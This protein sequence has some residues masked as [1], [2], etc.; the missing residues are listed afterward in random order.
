MAMIDYKS[1]AGAVIR[2]AIMIG[3]GLWFDNGGFELIVFVLPMII[4]NIVLFIGTVI[5]FEHFFRSLKWDDHLKEVEPPDEPDMPALYVPEEL[6]VKKNFKALAGAVIQ[7][8]ILA[9]VGIWFC[10]PLKFGFVLP[11]IA[12]FIGLSWGTYLCIVKF[13][14]S[15]KE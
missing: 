9:G 13:L 15:L 3:G 1:L 14:D 8:A 6:P 7:T 2:I 12:I 10:S 5:R 4:I 11:V